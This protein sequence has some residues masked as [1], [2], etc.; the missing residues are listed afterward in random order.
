MWRLHWLI[1]FL[2]TL[3]LGMSTSDAIADKPKRDVLLDKCDSR[4]IACESKCDLLIDING[5]VEKCRQ[6][7]TR[8]HNIC[9]RNVKD[10]YP[11]RT[12]GTGDPG[13][14]K[15]PVLSPK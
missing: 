2:T 11:A 15:R 3:A 8:K 6:E 14:N 10:A 13:Q 7:C 5:Q 9:T 4:Y 1:M 12:G